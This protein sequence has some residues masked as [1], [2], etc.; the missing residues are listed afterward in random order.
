MPTPR[1]VTDEVLRLVKEHRALVM[2]NFVPDFVSCMAG[3]DKNGLP[4]PVPE[5][6]TMEKVMEH[7]RHVGQLIGHEYVGV[8]ADSVGIPSMPEGILLLCVYI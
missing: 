7:I 3:N 8:S 4:D 6:A 2:V 5:G 1:N